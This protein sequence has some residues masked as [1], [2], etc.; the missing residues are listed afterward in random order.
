MGS[1]KGP[2]LKSRDSHSLFSTPFLTIWTDTPLPA[3]CSD[4]GE[5]ESDVLPKLAQEL[6]SALKTMG[7]THHR[8]SVTLQ[9][10][11]TYRS[12]FSNFSWAKQQAFSLPSLPR[13]GSKKRCLVSLQH[14]SGRQC[15]L[16]QIITCN[17]AAVDNPNFFRWPSLWSTGC[18]EDQSQI[19]WNLLSPFVPAVNHQCCQNSVLKHRHQ[20]RQF[21]IKQNAS[22]E[23]PLSHWH[24]H[25]TLLTIH[26]ISVGIYSF[27][28]EFIST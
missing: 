15:S 14:M 1:D 23:Q 7:N 24:C 8:N 26:I 22:T 12:A 21:Y 27:W 19:R 4:Y 3:H 6:G 9:E 11:I 18:S 10:Q 17:I 25:L 28:Q 2:P 13:P 5:G 20:D 16:T